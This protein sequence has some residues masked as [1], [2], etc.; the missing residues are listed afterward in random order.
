[1]DPSLAESTTRLLQ[2]IDDDIKSLE[3]SVRDLKSRRNSLVSISRL[4]PEAIAT[5]FSF[6]SLPGGPVLPSPNA[7][8]DRLGWLRVAHVC[9][10]W[11]EIALNQPRFWSHIDFNSL[12]SAGAS[13]ILARAKMAP[14]RLEAEVSHL[15]NTGR[16]LTFQEELKAHISHIAHLCIVA[17]SDHLERTLG[18]LV[19]PAPTLESLSLTSGLSSVVPS[20]L[21]QRTTIPDTFLEG[22]ATR[23]SCL[24]LTNCDISWKSP[25]LKGLR[26]LEIL[27]LSPH[28][29][30]RLED[31]LD[32]L[33]EMP[34][35]KRL[36]L[37]SATPLASL[38]A[39][40]ISGPDHTVTL[41]SLTQFDISASAEDCTV[42]LA[43][44]VLPALTWLHVNAE[45]HNFNGDDV[46]GVIPHIARNAHGSQD[47]EPLQ[48]VLISGE[49]RRAEILVWTVPDADMEVRD[50]TTLIG[51]AVSA[52]VVFSATGRDWLHGTDTAISDALL[53][54]LPTDSLSTLTVQNN[55][56][57]SKEFW[58]SHAPRLPLLERVRL[59]PM[60]V[61]AFEEMLAEDAAPNHPL[62]P[63]LTKLIFVNETLTVYK[64]LRLRDVLIQRVEQGVPIETLDLRT[65]HV[66]DR[67]I[68]L[69]AE[70]VVDVQ[71]PANTLKTGGSAFF[72][73]NGAGFF[74]GEEY[75]AEGSEEVTDEDEWEDQDY[76]G[77]EYGG[78]EGFDDS[79]PDNYWPYHIDYI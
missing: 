79:L 60:A 43:H 23:L 36:I 39:P 9:H 52:R 50:S 66:A 78:I 33:N 30:P 5:V 27:G 26:S 77:Y 10:L 22:D 35:L 53:A 75:A 65:C 55:A 46:R 76:E 13:E 28:A 56:Q 48:S 67:A 44:L 25:L 16:I 40:L 73:W 42:A 64:T 70:I 3:A 54:T 20:P 34:Q 59:V 8:P 32:T 71:S 29:R 74:L 69:L 49:R 58:L 41:P 62:L 14:L 63:S 12:T 61:A 2:A 1:M 47:T 37:H 24:E 7:K 18:R 68:Q 15:W 31:W 38:C 45:S 21:W 6:L 17:E 57:L 51:A 19:S 4:P 72:D 11:R